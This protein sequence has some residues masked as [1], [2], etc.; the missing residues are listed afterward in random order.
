M[1]ASAQSYSRWFGLD[2]DIESLGRSYETC[3]AIK[4]KQAA[5]PL[6]PWVWPDAPWSCNHV[7]YPGPFVGKML[8]GVVNAPSKW[9][10]VIIMN[11]YIPEHDGSTLDSVWLIWLARAIGFQ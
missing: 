10:E 6:H 9:T 8:F 3:Q 5:A 2:K 1:K 7:D 11:P 4:S